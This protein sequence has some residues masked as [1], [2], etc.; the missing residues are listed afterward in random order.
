MWLLFCVWC[1]SG[2]FFIQGFGFGSKY[3]GIGSGSNLILKTGKRSDLILLWTTV[4]TCFEN[5]NRH[6]SYLESLGA[7]GCDQSTWIWIRKPDITSLVGSGYNL[8]TRIRVRNP[9][10]SIGLLL[11]VKYSDFHQYK[12]P[13]HYGEPISLRKL[14][15][16]RLYLTLI[17]LG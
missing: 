15:R 12:I 7:C 6:V 9:D 13:L 5:R 16:T 1:I 8:N 10:I 3:I 14:G 17:V 4:S 11:L 2:L